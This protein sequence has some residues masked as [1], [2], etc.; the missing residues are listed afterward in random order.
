MSDETDRLLAA[1]LA[2]P[3][4]ERIR[5]VERL[6]ESLPPEGG[7]ETEEEFAAELERRAAEVAAGTADA[8]PWDKLREQT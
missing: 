6:L 1:A 3:E 7:A 4:E 8:I 2:L 5:L